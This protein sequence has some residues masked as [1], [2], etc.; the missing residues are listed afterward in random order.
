MIFTVKL[1]H[2]GSSTA[3]EGATAAEQKESRAGFDSTGAI[4]RRCSK[5]K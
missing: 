5:K 4:N 1:R 2:R 3:K